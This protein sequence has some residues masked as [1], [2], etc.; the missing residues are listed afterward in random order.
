[1]AQPDS[2]S[3]CR[4][5]IL[6]LGLMGG[7]LALRLRGQCQKL[8]GC[9]PDPATLS[10]ARQWDLADQVSD[11]PGNLLPQADLVILATPIREI[12]TL[13]DRLPALHP[14][15]AVVLD[16][17][18]TKNLIVQ[19]MQALPARFDP[20]GGHPMCGK[21]H[22]G[23]ANAD[24]DLYQ[25]APFALTPMPRTTQRARDLAEQLARLV[26]ANPLWLEA[27]T[28]DR[29]VA[30]TSHVPYL[31]ANALAA[32]TP[33]EAR[34][35]V[36]PGLRSTTRLAPSSWTM[37]HDILETNRPNILTGLQRFRRQ[38]EE[39]ESLLASGDLQALEMLTAQGAGNY[40]ALI[41]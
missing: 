9:D 28:H 33:L 10:L 14:G 41:Q 31:L 6:G 36:G 29:W 7:S 13:L 34:P 20:L 21:E 22:G 11:Q 32:I 30:A 16:L 26:G 18:S 19:R 3:N 25:S 12:I 39:L 37:M 38:I 40:E 4:I 5:V 27:E 35:L 1:M 24:P 15:Q 17:G 2:L 8:L 23:L